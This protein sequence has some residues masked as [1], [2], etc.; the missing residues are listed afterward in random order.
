MRLAETFQCMFVFVDSSV[1]VLKYLKSDKILVKR[2]FVNL[3]E[4]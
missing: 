3:F 4:F 2:A 1:K